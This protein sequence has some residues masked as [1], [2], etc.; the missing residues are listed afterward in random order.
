MTTDGGG[1]TSFFAGTNGSPNVFAYFPG[2]SISCTDPEQKCLRPLSTNVD[3]TY[4]F[5]VRCGADMFSTNMSQPIITFSRTGT[6]VSQTLSSVSFI[7]GSLGSGAG[8]DIFHGH[9]THGWA[10]FNSASTPGSGF[11]SSYSPNNHYDQCNGVS[12]T[13]SITYL[14][15]R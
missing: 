10:V 4:E 9:P 14:F 11:A 5:A 12:N 3:S 15:Y 2:S 13:S 7:D 1:W 8:A 6:T